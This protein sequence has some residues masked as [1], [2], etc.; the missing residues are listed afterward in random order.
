MGKKDKNKGATTSHFSAQSF[1]Q[2][3]E[4]KVIKHD[5]IRVI[6]LNALYLAILLGVFYTN[7]NTHYLENF[8]GKLF[9][10]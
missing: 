4:Q 9:H 3:A 5:M 10:F 8:F 2:E 6:M 7:K 1:T